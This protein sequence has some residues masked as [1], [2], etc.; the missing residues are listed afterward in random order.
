MSV[1]TFKSQYKK[2]AVSVFDFSSYKATHLKMWELQA[3]KYGERGYYDNG[4]KRIFPRCKRFKIINRKQRNMKTR[5][6][7]VNESSNESE[8]DGEINDDE[9]V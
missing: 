7:L 2:E 5:L 8:L 1:L 6:F 3:V 9:G 4:K